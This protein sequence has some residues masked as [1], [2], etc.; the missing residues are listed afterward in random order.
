MMQYGK[1]SH[2]QLLK[3]VQERVESARCHPYCLSL[4]SAAN[5]V[6]GLT[7]YG[8]LTRDK[9]EKEISYEVIPE[10]IEECRSLITSVLPKIVVDFGSSNSVI[11]VNS[12]QSKL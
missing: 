6:Q 10:K 4:E 12:V 7:L 5:C 1:C 9:K 8:A 3:L 11:C 2:V